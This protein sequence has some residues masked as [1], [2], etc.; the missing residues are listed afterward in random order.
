MY[1][2]I[3]NIREQKG[4]TLIELLI[5]VAIIGILAAIAIPAYIGAQEKARKSNLSKAAKSSEPDLMHWLNSAIKGVAG[6][7]G[8]ALIEI[9][10]NW[11]GT[12]N[13][14]D[15]TNTVLRGATSPANG[16][17]TRY[18][19]ART[20]GAGMNGAEPSPWQG[21]T[22]CTTT[23]LFAQNTTLTAVTAGSGAQCQVELDL[24]TASTIGVIATDNGPGGG[25]TG[26]QEMSRVVVSAE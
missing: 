19:I 21:M 5:V 3:N 25:G 13:A 16:V 4:F 1:K 6:Q 15:L 10:T 7:Q 12:V 20:G 17:V 18:V 26:K 2:A 11:D 22:G 24:I 8:A 9:D 14:T 23:V